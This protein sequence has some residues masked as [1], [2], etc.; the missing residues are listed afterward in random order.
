MKK[1]TY[2]IGGIVILGLP[3]WICIMTIMEMTGYYDPTVTMTG[4][5]TTRPLADFDTVRIMTDSHVIADEGL[6][7]FIEY[8]AE[9]DTTS[10]ICQEGYDEYMKCDVMNGTLNVS[11]ESKLIDGAGKDDENDFEKRKYVRFRAEPI[12]IVINKPIAEV[13]DGRVNVKITD[14]K[15]ESL[16]LK[17]DGR[18]ALENSNFDSLSIRPFEDLRWTDAR[19]KF[20]N[21]KVGRV[22]MMNFYRLPELRFDDDT[23][24]I[25]QVTIFGCDKVKLDFNV[26]SDHIDNMVFIPAE[27]G[28]RIAVVS[29]GIMTANFGK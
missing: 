19:I 13:V 21:S 8:S 7:I 26:D 25:G 6:N 23:S 12:K 18:I 14:V 17:T 4:A 9:A 28:S 27:K 3:I 11:F 16:T 2:I 24:G 29:Q 5:Q 10:L 1:T 15:S 20:N 22:S